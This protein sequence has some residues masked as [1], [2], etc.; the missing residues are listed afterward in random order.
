VPGIAHYRASEPVR[1]LY[2]ITIGEYLSGRGSL[3]SL[4]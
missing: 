2:R 4:V 1:S 3:R